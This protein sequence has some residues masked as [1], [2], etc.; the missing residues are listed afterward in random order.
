MQIGGEYPIYV[1]NLKKRSD[2]KQYVESLFNDHS[3]YN[4]S[5]IDAVDGSKDISHLIWEKPTNPNIRDIDL[6]AT[7]SHIKALQTWVVESSSEYALIFEDDISFETVGY[8]PFSWEEFVAKLPENFDVVQLSII[9]IQGHNLYLHKKQDREYSAAA[10][11]ISRE[12]AKNIILEYYTFGKYRFTNNESTVITDHKTIFG[13]E[14]SYAIP[15]FVTTNNFESD[16]KNLVGSTDKEI[17][18]LQEYNKNII[19]QLWKEN[20]KPIDELLNVK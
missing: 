5:F 19:V 3:I 1:I 15:L 20:T 6:A 11:L 4:Y 18:D 17:Y 16:N 10:Y 9:F 12:H 2:K 8:W 13:T 7:I 14:K